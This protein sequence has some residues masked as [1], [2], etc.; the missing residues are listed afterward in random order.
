MSSQCIEEL[1]YLILEENEYGKSTDTDEFVEDSAE[2]PHL[3]H[4]ADEEPDDDKDDD[5]DEYI[6]GSRFP[7]EPI[8]IIEHQ[9]NEKDVYCIL[10]SK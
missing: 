4:P 8:S 10:Y 2:K 3:Q 6:D 9:C 5:T 7:H 1:S